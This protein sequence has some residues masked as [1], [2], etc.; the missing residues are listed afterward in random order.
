MQ[1]LAPELRVTLPLVLAAALKQ[2][3]EGTLFLEVDYLQALELP[4]LWH[5]HPAPERV[6]E[7]VPEP[8]LIPE[9]GLE[10]QEDERS[11]QA[12]LC[13]NHSRHRIIVEPSR[14]S[15]SSN[16]LRA[17]PLLHPPVGGL[18]PIFA[19][20]PTAASG[21]PPHVPITPT[22]SQALSCTHQA[23]SPSGLAS[24][25]SRPPGLVAGRWS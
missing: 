6:K 18:R 21:A 9:T 2:L 5:Q 7:R 13:M 19:P 10:L 24:M 23:L 17:P 14:E 16:S 25:G 15:Q 12:R 1:A 4:R 8:A 22:H 20:C 11:P 3:L